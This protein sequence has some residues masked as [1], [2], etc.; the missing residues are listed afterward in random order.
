MLVIVLPSLSRCWQGSARVTAETSREPADNPRFEDQVFAFRGPGLRETRG[1][2]LLPQGR[3]ITW[4]LQAM[5][6][7]KYW[8]PVTPR[9]Q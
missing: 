9:T 5:Y 2:S 6:T 1:C 3:E 4:C 7:T 8:V